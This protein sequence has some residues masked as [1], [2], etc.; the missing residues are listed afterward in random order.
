MFVPTIIH[1]IAVLPGYLITF[2]IS[3]VAM[4]IN[5]VT[6]KVTE[7]PMLRCWIITAMRHPFEND[8][9]DA[10]LSPTYRHFISQ[11]HMFRIRCLYIVRLHI[12]LHQ[13]R[14]V[15]KIS[16]PCVIPL[17]QFQ[18]LIRQPAHALF[19]GNAPHLLPI[20]LWCNRQYLFIDGNI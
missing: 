9:L 20:H 13:S 12:P 19:H 14:S 5:Q 4:L 2:S 3:A 11:S 16:T 18:C 7:L 6:V 15:R 8:G 1:S 10:F 17:Q